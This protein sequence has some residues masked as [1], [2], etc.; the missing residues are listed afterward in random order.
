[1]GIKFNELGVLKH[2]M[3]LYNLPK[4]VFIHCRSKLGF[5]M[6]ECYCLEYYY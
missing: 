1:M 6:A 4:L 5:I 3:D 2:V